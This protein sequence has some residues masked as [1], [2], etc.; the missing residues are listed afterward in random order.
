VKRHSLTIQCRISPS[1]RLL[2]SAFA[3]H[4]TVFRPV[5]PCCGCGLGLH[6]LAVC[7]IPW[8][9]IEAAP[10]GLDQHSLW[11]PLPEAADSGGANVGRGH[12]WTSTTSRWE[13][14]PA[15]AWLPRATHPRSRTCHLR[16]KCCADASGRYNA[17]P[18]AAPLAQVIV[19][20]PW[21]LLS[22]H[23]LV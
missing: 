21:G 19:P 14:S 11:R 9:D 10:V 6:W 15:R 20:C 12:Q 4:A 5:F 23:S 13:R 18:R 3:V 16:C 1:S 17:R 8:R 7:N 2:V 22:G